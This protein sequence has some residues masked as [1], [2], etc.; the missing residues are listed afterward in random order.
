[1]KASVARRENSS[2]K[3]TLL[4]CEKYFPPE[5]KSQEERPPT[6]H[7]QTLSSAFGKRCS[8]KSETSRGLGHDPFIAI[9]LHRGIAH[10]KGEYGFP[11]PRKEN[12]LVENLSS[13]NT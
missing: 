8:S 1:M 11:I 13:V 4:R 5:Q 10:K 6:Q 7:P 12:F 2:K 3:R 9:L